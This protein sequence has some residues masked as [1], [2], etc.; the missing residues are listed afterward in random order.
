MKKNFIIGLCAIAAVAVLF[1]GI[2]FLKGINIFK[3]SNYYQASYTNVAGLQV[4]AP[5]TVNGFKVGQVSEI[6]YQYNNPGHIL[7]EMSLDK[8][9]KVPR[10]SKASIAV[11]L[12]GTASVALIL[13]PGT[14]FIPV[15]GT[16]EGI[17]PATLVDNIS[18]DLMPSVTAIVP[19]VD[20]LLTNV[21]ALVANPAL[22]ASISRLDAITAQLSSTLAALDKS[23][24]ALPG[25]M[26]NIQAITQNIDTVSANLASITHD[27]KQGEIDST[28]TNL[29][30]VSTDLAALT[31]SLNTSESTL[32]Q[33]VKDPALYD[34]L[35]RA[36]MSLDSLLVDIK[37]N[38]K[39][40]ISIKVF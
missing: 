6:N 12:L 34:N 10:G 28:L 30:R 8:N 39:R 2:D 24:K 35:A 25:V 7:V 31:S 13:A 18:Q 20:T 17:T 27:I 16:M 38:P 15:G 9:L 5:V 33:L 3:P 36:S 32:G 22:A 26:T 11:D 21:N 37:K 40:Y 14:D 19:K 23:V 1:F 4:S 29:N